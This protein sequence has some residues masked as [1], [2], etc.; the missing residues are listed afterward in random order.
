MKKAYSDASG[1]TLLRIHLFRHRTVT[2]MRV[3][4]TPAAPTS[5][6]ESSEHAS[7]VAEAKTYATDA[8]AQGLFRNRGVLRERA[9]HGT[10]GLARPP[11]RTAQCDFSIALSK[12][13]FFLCC[14]GLVGSTMWDAI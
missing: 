7:A 4:K 5:R 1:N 13:V 11:G 9:K 8:V 2:N 3:A 6:S 14:C 10:S 12:N